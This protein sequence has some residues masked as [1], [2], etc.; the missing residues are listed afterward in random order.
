MAI[1]KSFQ[2]GV[3]KKVDFGSG[4]QFDE[5]ENAGIDRLKAPDTDRPVW[6]LF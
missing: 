5:I 3:V 1:G 4:E 2:M 6:G